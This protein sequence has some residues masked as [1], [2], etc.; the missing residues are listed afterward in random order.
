M[1][2]KKF[3]QML[4][5]QILSAMTVT[6]CMMIDSIMIGRFLGVYSMTAY[7]L[8]TPILLVFAALGAMISA[9]IQV[10]CGKT[11]GSG[12]QESAI[13]CYSTSIVAALGIALLALVLIFTVPN[14]ICMIL[15]T[16]S[17]SPTNQVF[18]LTKNYLTGFIIG[19]PAFIFAQIMV[20]FVQ[21]AGEQ[22]RLIL[23]VGIMTVSDIILDLLSVF[24]F[25]GGMLGMGLAS[26]ISYYAA[27]AIGLSYFFSKKCLFKFRFKSIHRKTIVQMLK[28]GVPTV[29]NQLSLVLLVYVFNHIL[30]NVNG[31]LAVAAYSVITT[32]SNLCYS[33]GSGVAAV[34]LTLSSVFFGDEDRTSL[35][36]LMRIMTLYAIILDVIVTIAV[37]FASPVM[38]GLFLTRQDAR[39]MAVTGLRLFALCLVP[40]SLNTSLKNYYQGTGRTPLTEL[41]SVLQ[42]FAFPA[43]SGFL[44]SRVIGTTGV[45]MA[46]FFGETLAL[47]VICCIVWKK[48]GHVTF[49]AEAFA[50]LHS[51]I[52][53]PAKD[54]FEVTVRTREE[55]TSA[56]IAIGEF[57]KA[58]HEDERIS[59][60]VSL[61]V[62]EMAFN[63]IEHGFGMDDLD[64][65]IDIRYMVKNEK[66]TLRI[67]DDCKGFDPIAYNDLHKSDDQ[68]AHFGIRMAF[69]K[70]KD[71]MYISS[72]GLNNLTIVF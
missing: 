42:N 51:D 40:C 19:A 6:I 63:I 49:T 26:S 25:K 23:A 52:G 62:E 47:L 44:L 53:V 9:G 16:G 1:I 8:A 64:H 57:C 14:Q 61:C 48:N 59:Y 13:S 50:M 27:V 46:F 33:F 18:H 30:L 37:Q 71:T 54:C 65:S 7:G 38:V 22:K 60:N 31:K 2:K 58:H 56:S 67:R 21:I 43:L 28:N 39:S 55:V 24:V 11:M 3:R 66:R 4:L 72:L 36:S 10:V 17:P 29:I 5:T 32:V 15:G 12:D 70:A 34:A 20:P 68:T 45:W 35:L 41:I 69:S